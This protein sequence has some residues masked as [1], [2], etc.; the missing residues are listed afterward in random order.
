[1]VK[2]TIPLSAVSVSGALF[3]WY[4]NNCVLRSD[5]IKG[6]DGANVTAEDSFSL[7]FAQIN[8]LL[9]NGGDAEFYLMAVHADIDLLGDTVP[10][11]LPNR[12][13]YDTSGGQI[14]KTF[15]NWLV[16]GA[17]FW[18][19]DDNTEILFYTNP[20]AG[21]EDK[22]LKGSEI[23]LIDDLANCIGILKISDAEALVATGWTKL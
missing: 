16:P 1:M 19:K 23:K 9:T 12:I 3:N 4:Y 2:L 8:T 13:T 11:G 5:I 18:K 6:I 22:Y 15:N 10:V 21:N 20:F 14:A 7:T 17:E